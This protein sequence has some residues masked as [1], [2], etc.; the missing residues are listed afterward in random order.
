MRNTWVECTT[1]V[2]AM[3]S[4]TRSDSR[5]HGSEKTPEREIDGIIRRRNHPRRPR[6][7]LEQGHRLF[8]HLLRRICRK[9]RAFP[10][11][12]VF[13]TLQESVGTSFRHLKSK[14]KK[15]KCQSKGKKKCNYHSIQGCDL[16]R[17]VLEQEVSEE[18]KKNKNLDDTASHTSCMPDE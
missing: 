3:K 11:Q 15:K 16:Q 6:Q 2:V 17:R 4:D 10:C 18:S 1:G 14:K 5:S 9:D 13:H 7:T 8:L 12:K